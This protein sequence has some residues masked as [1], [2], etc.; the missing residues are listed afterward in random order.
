[1]GLGYSSSRAPTTSYTSK[2]ASAAAT[3]LP[4]PSNVNQQSQQATQSDPS[5]T[6]SGIASNHGK[7]SMLYAA[8]GDAIGFKNGDW[9]FNKSTDDIMKQANQLGGIHAI[10]VN[11]KDWPVS[12]DTV[13]HAATAIAL[14]E[15]FHP[16]ADVR[17]EITLL[18][19][20]ARPDFV[21]QMMQCG[22]IV[23]GAN[24]KLTSDYY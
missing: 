4:I 9:E 24:R 22:V 13:M 10:K 5:I 16:S 18:S 11:V 19:Q 3:S 15:S 21:I 1:M 14:I 7:A 8:L 2:T 23:A 6:D 12:D 20:A 17:R